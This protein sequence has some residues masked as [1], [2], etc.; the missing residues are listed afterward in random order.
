VE[1]LAFGVAAILA[2]AFAAIRL[3][4]ASRR[5]AALFEFAVLFGMEYSPVD[6]FGLIDHRFDL[7]D[8]GD[9]ARCQN[10]VW[11]N[12]HG[13]GVKVGELR[14][15]PN[16]DRR[17]QEIHQAT[18]RY[19]FAVVEFDAWLPDLTIRPDPLAGLSEDLLLDRLRFESDEFNRMYRV[20][21]A[22]EQFAYKLIDARMILW[23]QE[24][25]QTFPFDFQ[26][27]GNRLLVWCNRLKP[28]ALIP[29]F[30]AAKG[31]VDHIPSVVL[32]DNPLLTPK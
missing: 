23:L 29:L 2:V 6:P 8:R 24:I 22:D 31:F 15:K 14:F 13:M 28:L 27:N 12:W 17:N 9:G 3:T 25:G 5:R 1:F 19:S 7:F 26:V 4:Q 20:V 30:G 32:R 18:K 21:C 11:G 16:R 10:V